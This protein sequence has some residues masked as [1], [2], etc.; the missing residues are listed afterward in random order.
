[1]AEQPIEPIHQFKISNLLNIGTFG[2]DVSAMIPPS[3][4]AALRRAIATG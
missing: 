2:G 1:M 3:A 4:L